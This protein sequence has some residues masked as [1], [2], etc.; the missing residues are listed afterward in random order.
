MNVFGLFRSQLS[1]R[2]APLS[3][4]KPEQELVVLYVGINREAQSLE[5]LALLASG[6][7]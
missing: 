3:F 4:P 5:S 2:L 1:F 7:G 6:A